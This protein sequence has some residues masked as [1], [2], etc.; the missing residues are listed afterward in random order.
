MNFLLSIVILCS[1]AV[2]S[3][4]ISG[5]SYLKGALE[6]VWVGTTTSSLSLESTSDLDSNLTGLKIFKPLEEMD[7]QIVKS[8]SSSCI[9]GETTAKFLYNQAQTIS[10]KDSSLFSI[11]RADNKINLGQSS[12]LPLGTM[13]AHIHVVENAT[14][15]L[16]NGLTASGNSYQI[17]GNIYGLTAS[18][19]HLWMGQLYAKKKDG[20]YVTLNSGIDR[21]SLSLS[22]RMLGVLTSNS[23]ETDS[24]YWQIIKLNYQWVKDEITANYRNIS[25]L[26]KE[27]RWIILPQGTK[28][29]RVRGISGKTYL[30][31]N[32]L[33][34]KVLNLE[35]LPKGFYFI[36]TNSKPV[37][38]IFIE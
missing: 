27:T 26:I 3:C 2:F 4:P 15:T 6:Y 21:D 33:E 28:W 8:F 1:A 35:N 18:Q 37:E 11:Y 19:S 16:N 9:W 38:K 5:K 14:D 22:D 23:I 36:E 29:V 20:N 32:Q 24:V 12:Y 34:D 10:E 25:R 31:K 17:N 30:E 13:E 7:Y